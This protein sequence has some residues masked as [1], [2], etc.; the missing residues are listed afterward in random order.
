MVS[1]SAGNI[2]KP[3]RRTARSA[4]PAACACLLLMAGCATPVPHGQHAMPA[5][6]SAPATAP[7]TT[8]PVQATPALDLGTLTDL[9]GIIPQLAAKRVVFVGEQHDRYDHH[10]TQLEIIRRLHALDPR[11]AIGM[12][13]FQQPFQAALD[14]YVAGRLTEAEMLRRTGYFTRWRFDYRHYA[15][16][17]RY[18]REHRLPVIALNVPEELTRKVARDGLES[19]SAAEQ[20]QLPAEIDRSDSD[21]ERRLLDIFRQHPHSGRSFEAFLNVQL[22]WD[23]GMAERAA[24]YLA[25]HPEQRLVVLAGAGHLA[26]GSGIPHRLTRRLPVS[27]AIVLN[28]WT[29]ALEPGLAD[30]IL[31]TTPRALPPAG[32]FGLFLETGDGVPTV[33]NCM[34]D[35]PCTRAG[36]QPGDRFL[37]IDGEPVQDMTDLKLAM[38]DKQPGDTVTLR[39]S[40]KRWLAAPRE[41]SYSIELR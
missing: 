13:A 9:D 31:L 28:D 36:L 2:P 40:R 26:R 8:V 15:P 30:F 3:A 32:K 39:I 12:E 33:E 16:I 19:L 21:Y 18:A 5:L 41:L 10:Q 27:S 22:L 14:D 29:G 23:E 34:P 4:L 7:A 35:S 37:S 11:L 20:A 25:A 24:T 17:L 6:P 38:W 1:N